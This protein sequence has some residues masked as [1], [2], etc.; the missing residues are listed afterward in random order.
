MI[1]LFNKCKNTTFGQN[2]IMKLLQMLIS[3]RAMA[4]LLFIF[5]IAIGVGTFVEN[6]YDTITA[7]LVIYNAKYFELILVLLAIVFLYNIKRYK[8]LSLKKS[9]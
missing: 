8:L 3:T 6:S 1:I 9:I 5:A 2:N 7:R 4:I